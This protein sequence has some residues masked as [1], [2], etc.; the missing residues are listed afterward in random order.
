[1]QLQAAV[2]L[3]SSR[4]GGRVHM[5]GVLLWMDTSSLRRTGWGDAEEE[6]P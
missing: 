1:M 3:A 4:C 5:P 2:L 6:L